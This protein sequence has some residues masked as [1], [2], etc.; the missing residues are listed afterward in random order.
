MHSL[1][2]VDDEPMIVEGLYHNIHW[3][4]SGFSDVYMA[5]SAEEALLILSRCRVDIVVA[6]ISMP[7][8]N[9]IGLCE[10]ILAQWP[11]SKVIFLSGYR[12][13][14]YARRAVE[15]GVYQYL[16]KP[17][18]YEDI[19]ATVEGALEQFKRDLEQKNL[20]A[21]VERRAGEFQAMARDRL[22]GD[23]L[24]YGAL[25][26]DAG[27]LEDAGI[28]LSPGM[29]GFELLIR[30][31]GAPGPLA[32]LGAQALAERLLPGYAQAYGLPIRRDRLLLA[33][34]NEN[35]EDAEALR[36]RCLSGLDAL[37][38]AVEKSLGCP[39][40]AF[41]SAVAAADEMSALF[42]PLR[43]AMDRA[44]AE[45]QLLA[46]P[47][48]VAPPMDAGALNRA[49]AALDASAARQWMECATAS[50]QGALCRLAAAELIRALIGDAMGRGLTAAELEAACPML[51]S[52]A[53]FS[54]E[55]D[56]LNIAC[57]HAIDAY[58]ALALD[59]RQSQR[60]MLVAAV[61]R[62][63]D[64][65]MEGGITVA[66]LAEAFSYN[67]SYL[68]Q[69]IR[70]ETGQSLGE[71]VI[72]MRVER[73]CALLARGARVQDAALAVGYDNLA[74]FSRLFKKKMGM[75]PRAYADRT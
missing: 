63:I 64:E 3:E 73:A 44:P 33:L 53:A 60:D 54:L 55:P 22:L 11:L 72:S 28:A 1:L 38:A 16:V 47:A 5:G 6:D 46:V 30:L 17:V 51:L 69:L 27:E 25:R 43:A 26:A 10:R 61:R 37:Q 56:A 68:S 20:I 19:Q 70:Q 4:E 39:M 36:R 18:R 31:H 62:R 41:V 58:V 75:S 14:D 7:G 45:P 71:M 2:L 12:D 35:R 15:L 32:Q 40:S 42:G 8:L 23:W 24:I 21:E 13:F 59:C 49:I 65:H 66:G 52:P 74:H 34:M 48:G 50:R 57:G 9:G 29:Y 67:A